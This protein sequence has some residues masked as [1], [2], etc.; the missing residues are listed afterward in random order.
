MKQLAAAPRIRNV[1]KF[2][3]SFSLRMIQKSQ[4]LLNFDNCNSLGGSE[5]KMLSMTPSEEYLRQA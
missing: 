5:S 1:K 2:S 3:P 4:G